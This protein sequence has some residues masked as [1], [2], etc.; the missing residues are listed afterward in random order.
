MP[1]LVAAPQLDA[2]PDY[3]RVLEDLKTAFARPD[4]SFQLAREEI[5]YRNTGT[6]GRGGPTSHFHL[7]GETEEGRWIA[8]TLVVYH[9][10]KMDIQVCVCLF[11][12][13]LLIHIDKVNNRKVQ[14]PS[15][16]HKEYFQKLFAE[17]MRQ[18]FPS[19]C[20]PRG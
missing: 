13:S 6:G 18:A 11:N 10:G 17:T 8:L 9:T 1:S 16:E 5:D 4:S 14:D 12:F 20:I 3:N 19:Y 7:L 2:S 15:A